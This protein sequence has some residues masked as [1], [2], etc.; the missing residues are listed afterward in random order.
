MNQDLLLPAVRKWI[1]E[2]TASDAKK[3]A[4]AKNPFPSIE[5]PELLNQLATRAK[6]KEK[7]PTWF[8]RENVVFPSKISLEQTSS[9]K[10]AEYKSSLVSGDSL[11]DLTGGFGVDDFYFAKK[12]KSVLHCELNAEL[13]EIAAHNF[14]QLGA[15]N[16]VCESG[17]SEE[18]LSK[19]DKRFDWIYV[20]PSRRNDAKGKVFMLADCLPN[21]PDSLDFYFSK[22]DNI[23]I[24]A[25]P[26]LDISAGLKELRN[27]SEIHI[28]ALENEVKE[29]LF[30]LRKN[31]ESDIE[32]KCI[33]LLKYKIQ[34][35]IFKMSEMEIDSHF[36]SPKKYLFEPNPTIYKSGAFDLVGRRFGLEKLDRHSHLYTSDQ[37]VSDFPG[38]IFEIEKAIDYDKVAMK[39]NLQGTKANVSVRN[40]P[41]TVDKLR[42]KW[43]ISDGGS[44][45]TFF[46]TVNTKD[47]IV[48]F[49]A[50]I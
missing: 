11:I 20:D 44:V 24:K 16:I 19:S 29:L 48:L 42:A 45:Y 13:S 21:V 2:N 6:S 15:S 22:S 38:R 4:F 39:E 7:L 3:L 36:G 10:T 12:V 33:N 47:K 35:F 49:C 28:V 32:I 27:V 46:T 1:L 34:E 14:K 41:E 8:A 18:I 30:V 25:A 23:L 37:L 31:F 17:N 26:L 5:Y 40:F 9:E 50:K 43:K